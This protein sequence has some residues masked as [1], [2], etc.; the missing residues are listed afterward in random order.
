MTKSK[1]IILAT[2]LCF[3]GCTVSKKIIETGNNNSSRKILIATENSEF[4]KEV[5]DRLI[6]KLGMQD[7]YF[8]IISLKQLEEVDRG[9]YGAI[10]LVCKVTA[11]KIQARANTFINKELANPKLIIFLTSGSGDPL[12]EFNTADMSGVDAI[13]SAS[14]ISEVEKLAD[15]LKKLL[16]KRF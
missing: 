13:T 8:R 6:E 15:Q 1:L 9:Q 14:R 4:K 16:I 3:L 11:G 10:L 12:S 2:I 5:V 7:Y